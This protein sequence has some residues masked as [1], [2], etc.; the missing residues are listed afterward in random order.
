[1]SLIHIFT[2]PTNRDVVVIFSFPNQLSP[3]IVDHNSSTFV[4]GAINIF[5]VEIIIIPI[6]IRSEIIE[7]PQIAEQNTRVCLLYTSD[8]ANEM[9][10]CLYI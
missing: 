6:A 4:I 7:W 5:N 9:T 3:T 2:C 1:M 8:A 10:R